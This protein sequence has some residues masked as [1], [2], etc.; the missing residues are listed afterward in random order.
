[1][2]LRIRYKSFLV[3]LGIMGAVAR[4]T[5]TRRFALRGPVG[6]SD[7]SLSDSGIGEKSKRVTE[8]RFSRGRPRSW[9]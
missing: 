5:A 9:T 2:V 1:M 7:K 4:I 6:W 8:G 3:Y